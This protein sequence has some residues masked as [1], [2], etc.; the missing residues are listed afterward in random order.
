M[1]ASHNDITTAASPRRPTVAA[2]V[3]QIA[4]QLMLR[5]GEVITEKLAIERARNIVAALPLD[6]GGAT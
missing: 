3:K 2:L 4:A 1:L 5:K 6:V